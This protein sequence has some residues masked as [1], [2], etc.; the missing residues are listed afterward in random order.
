MVK[1]GSSLTEGKGK[2][3]RGL[4]VALVASL[5][6]LATL[7]A[8]SPAFA[9]S[10]KKEEFAPFADCPVESAPDCVVATT[11]SGEFVLDLKKVAIDKTIT[12]QGGLPTALDAQ[13]L[14][15]AVGGE[16]LSKT[17]LTIP[18]GLTGIEGLEG[19]GGEVTA[20]AE[21]AGPPSSVVINRGYFV[22]DYPDAVTLP[23]KVKLSNEV[24]G[25]ECYI[26][27]DSEPIVLHLTA[28][29]TSPP[30]PAQPITG[31]KGTFVEIDKDNI[32]KFEGTSLVDNDFAVPGASGCG[33]SL[34]PIVD[35]V[36]DADVGIPAPAGLST[37]IMKG[38]L[39]EA[40][41]EEV[42]KYKP[43]PKK[44]KK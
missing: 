3:S 41:A 43:K 10:A 39:E 4:A 16:T 34:S 31:S 22:F 13:P 19:I 35:A 29:T 44:E 8:A 33:G 18:G 15:A 28:G 36:V 14:I 17:P 30:F 32:R 25:N 27:S 2:R 1:K 9:S 20:T 7:G 42:E 26:G 5:A 23:L 12:L 38:A 11:T 6:T 37:A 21:I 24:L 40:Y